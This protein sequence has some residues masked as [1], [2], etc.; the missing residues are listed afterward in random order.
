MA[1][2]KLVSQAT[3]TFGKPSSCDS[4][5]GQLTQNASH[6]EVTPLRKKLTLLACHLCGD[7]TKTKAFLHKQQISSST[8]GEN[9]RINNTEHI[10]VS[11][12]YSVLKREINPVRPSI[13]MAVE[14]LTE[15][16]DL[17]LG[18]SSINTARCALSAILECPSSSNS[19]FG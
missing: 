15:L 2:S 7:S 1:K 12:Y 5:E 10:L 4:S 11:G 17:G 16:Y 18:Y 8:L 9:P 6:S 14:F 19:T 13:T 3:Q